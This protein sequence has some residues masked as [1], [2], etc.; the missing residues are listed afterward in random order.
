ME[1]HARQQLPAFS[2]HG[3]DPAERAAQRERLREHVREWEAEHGLIDPAIR[4]EI[5]AKMADWPS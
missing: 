3:D 2:P 1:P 5:R 4:D